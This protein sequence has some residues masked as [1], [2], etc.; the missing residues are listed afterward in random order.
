MELKFL[1]ISIFRLLDLTF[2]NDLTWNNYIESIAKSAAMKIGSLY[3]ARNFL[4]SESIL[5]LYK[6]TIRPCLEYC[7]HICLVLLLIVL[8][9]LT[10]YRGELLTLLD[11]IF[12][13][14]YSPYLIA[15]MLHHCLY[16]INTS[17][18]VVLTN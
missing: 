12:A 10:A 13:Q 4:S 8:V 9:F 15:A 6:A 2:S 18:V 5:Y 1:R 3:R 17:M 16:F 11:L 7:C 14:I